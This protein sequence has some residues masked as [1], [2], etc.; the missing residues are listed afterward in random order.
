MGSG[1]D[2]LWHS[3]RKGYPCRSGAIRHSLRSI[4]HLGIGFQCHRG[5]D[6]QEIQAAQFEVVCVTGSV[7]SL[8]N[9]PRHPDKNK[10]KEV[11]QEK[12]VQVSKAY[13]ALTDDEVRKNWEEYGNP[14]GKQT[15]S[16][17]IALP[18]WIV[19]PSNTI[20]VLAV[21]AALFGFLLPYFVGKW[22]SQSKKFTKDHVLN[23]TMGIYFQE[24]KEG[25]DVKRMLELLCASMEF[26][27]DVPHRGER[28][29]DAVMALFRA[30]KDAV[31]SKTGERMELPK[32]VSELV[33][34]LV[35]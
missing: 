19:E 1:L 15:F 9:T 25:M 2:C 8:M 20:P 29:T 7:I 28:D 18:S 26:K 13:Q 34:E 23:Y 4:C 32:K 14:D 10:D 33:F 35:L 30:V 24:F 11:A 17:G 27:E 6:P 21:Y 5:R 16:F 12:F 31:Y 3:P 22:W